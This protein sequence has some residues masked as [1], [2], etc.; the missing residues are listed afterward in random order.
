MPWPERFWEKVDRTQSCWIWTGALVNGYGVIRA[1]GSRRMLKAH[2]VAY[3]LMVGSIP[4]GLVIDHLCR[5]PACVNPAHLEPVTQ[6][7]NVLRGNAPAAQQVHITHCPRGH[8]YN[9][10]NTYWQGRK[11]SCRICR[12][13]RHRVGAEL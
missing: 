6:R 13:D 5:N 3:E 10:E 12:R 1:S 4:E 9:I 8:E 11:R 7:V 2:R